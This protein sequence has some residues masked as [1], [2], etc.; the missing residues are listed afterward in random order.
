MP[1]PS[2]PGTLRFLSARIRAERRVRVVIVSAALVVVGVY[3]LWF[4][5]GQNLPARPAK[6]RI[7]AYFAFRLI[8][9]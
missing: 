3:P 7:Q 5:P 6:A 8:R 1:K 4:C 2:A 9:R